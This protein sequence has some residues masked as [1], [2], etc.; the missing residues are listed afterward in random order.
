MLTDFHRE[1]EQLHIDIQEKVAK[2]LKL[3][4]YIVQIVKYIYF[5][6]GAIFISLPFLV[7]IF[8]DEKKV[9]LFGFVLPGIYYTKSPGYE[10]NWTFQLFQTYCVLVG[11]NATVGFYATFLLNGRLQL[12][13]LIA[14]LKKL[15][16]FIELNG[17]KL[18][19]QR[20]LSDIIEKH[21]AHTRYTRIIMFKHIH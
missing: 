9:L 15:N 11:A 4:Y 17:D 21:K 16:T 20:M 3:C 6:G 13:V 19:Q 18:E 2:Q 8:T 10:I 12:D 14:L 5:I 7:M 1:N